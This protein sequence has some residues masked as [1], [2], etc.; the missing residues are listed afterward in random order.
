[1]Q[2]LDDCVHCI[3]QI[4]ATCK[5]KVATKALFV[6]DCDEQALIAKIYLSGYSNL[7]Q[8]RRPQGLA[9]VNEKFNRPKWIM[10]PNEANE[11]LQAGQVDVVTRWFQEPSTSVCGEGAEN[12]TVNVI[13]GGGELCPLIQ[14]YI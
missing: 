12:T 14:F 3:G 4:T 11:A 8:C 10:Q 5:W 7:H 13:K 6:G 1:M 2:R 9:R